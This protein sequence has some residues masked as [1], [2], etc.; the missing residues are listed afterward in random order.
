MKFKNKQEVREY[1]WKNIASL[2]KYNPY[3]KIPNFLGAEKACERIRELEEY[4]NSKYLFSAPDSVLLKLREIALIDQKVLLVAKPK[5]KGFWLLDRYIKPTIKAMDQFG[6]SVRLNELD[7]KIDLFIQGCV[8]VDKMGNRIGKG[9]G[10][11]DKE[12]HLLKDHGLLS[13]DC[14]FIVIAHDMQVFDDLSYLMDEHDVKA[15][16][17]LTP[18]RIIRTKTFL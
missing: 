8:A 18:S 15:D 1:V 17:I 5:I 6:K 10:F 13:D 2:C 11:G 16:I 14:L 9:S 3:G 7:I 12:Y 4:K